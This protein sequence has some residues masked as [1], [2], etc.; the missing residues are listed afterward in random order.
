MFILKKRETNNSF[1]IKIG[2]IALVLII[3]YHIF[4]QIACQHSH[5]LPDGTVITHSHPY[6]KSDDTE[7]LKKHHH[8]NLELFVIGQSTLL[9]QVLFLV[10]IFLI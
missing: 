8:S 10:Y 1:C 5:I 7:P 4:N 6:N 3:G 2:S 9:L